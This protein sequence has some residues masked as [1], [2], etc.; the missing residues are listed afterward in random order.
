MA[1]PIFIRIGSGPTVDL[2]EFVATIDN[3]LGLLKDVDSAVSDKKR[4]NLRWRV[5][6]LRDDPSPLVGVTPLLLR[7][8]VNDTGY[9][10]EREVIGNVV[11][12]TEKGERSKYFSDSALTKVENIAKI[13]KTVGESKIYTGNRGDFN[14]STIVNVKTFTQVQDLRNVF[15]VS[16]GSVAGSLDSISV[17]RGK[18]EFRVWDENTNRPVRCKFTDA[19]VNA[20]KDLL[21]NRVLVSGNVQSDRYGKPISMVAETLAAASLGML[22]PIESLMGSVPNLTGGLSIKE[23]LEDLD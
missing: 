15:S 19:Q 8:S 4:G 6:T 16:F 13:S 20:V 1:E 18:R 21:G 11:S 22:P 17:H 12:L 10:V 14:L 7:T 2:P 5:T 3:F 23:Y 9:F